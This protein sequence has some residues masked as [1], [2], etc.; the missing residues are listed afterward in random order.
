MM[1]NN[2]KT[3]AFQRNPALN[4]RHTH[5][6]NS[7]LNGGERAYSQNLTRNYHSFITF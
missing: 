5:G 6:P 2:G 7:R 1:K 4:R 3:T